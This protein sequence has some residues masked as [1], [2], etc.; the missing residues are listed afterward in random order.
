MRDSKSFNW[1][2]KT[3]KYNW[4]QMLAP[5]QEKNESYELSLVWTRR[6]AF[7]G[8]VDSALLSQKYSLDSSATNS[9]ETKIIV[10]DQF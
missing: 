4:K 7:S 9:L 10:S 6:Y 3:Q 2:T 1:V 5:Y 8:F